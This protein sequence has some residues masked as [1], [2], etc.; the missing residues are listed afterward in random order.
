MPLLPERRVWPRLQPRCRDRDSRGSKNSPQAS[1]LRRASTHAL[2]P[3]LFDTESQTVNT[4]EVTIAGRE[5]IGQAG[6]PA[7]DVQPDLE[8]AHPPLQGQE[9]E[10]G[11]HGPTRATLNRSKLATT[12]LMVLIVAVLSLTVV[13]GLV[14]G[15]VTKQIPVGIALAGA[16]ATVVSVF[17]GIYYYHNK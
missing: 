14:L 13:P 5:S 17:A 1:H 2:H 12:R 7:H 15:V 8:S 3:Q 16:S 9:A 4:Q 10:D 6:A 11:G